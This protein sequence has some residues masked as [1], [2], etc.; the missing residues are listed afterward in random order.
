MKQGAIKWK[1]LAACLDSHHRAGRRRIARIIQDDLG[2]SLAS[3]KMELWLLQ[4]DFTPEQHPMWI[5]TGALLRRA[6][7]TLETANRISANLHPAILTHLGLEA[8][9]EWQ[10][11]AFEEETGIQCKFMATSRRIP[12]S[13]RRSTALFQIVQECLAYAAQCLRPSEITVHLSGC[14][15]SMV[16]E[17]TIRNKPVE[18]VGCVQKVSQAIL[19]RV[20]LLDGTLIIR[21]GAA[22]RI[23][24]VIPL[25]VSR[26]K[27]S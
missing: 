23:R 21:K 16:L 7:E 5:K 18:N 8:A 10:V 20:R 19:A 2:Q 12:L 1:S 24:A 4:Q 14:S 3:L 9:L 15:N 26:V 22:L 6:A 25:R 11:A 27:T 13:S 17:I